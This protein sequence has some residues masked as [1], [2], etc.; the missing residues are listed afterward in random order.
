MEKDAGLIDKSRKALRDT[1][2]RA[3]ES[4]WQEQGAIGKAKHLAKATFPETAE[5]LQTGMNKARQFLWKKMSAGQ[6]AKYLL[7][8][9]I[10]L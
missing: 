10:G 2:S 8:K 7:A 3:R 1:M 6:K 4:A 9:V 5:A